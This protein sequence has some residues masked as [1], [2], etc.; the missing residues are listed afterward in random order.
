MQVFEYPFFIKLL[1]RFG[2]IPVTVLLL[3]YLVLSVTRVDNDLVYIIPIVV[4]FGLIY[5]INKRYISLYQVLPYK[6]IA[7]DEKIICSNFLFRNKEVIVYYKDIDSMSGGIFSGKL[8]GLMQ[9]CDG[10]NKICIG[11]FEN[12]RNVKSLQTLILSRVNKNVYDNVVES[13]GLR[14]KK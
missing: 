10:R 2:N 9:L 7:D 12:I 8:R 5:F 13:V 4:T 3:I 11:F 1:Y 14:N 6:I